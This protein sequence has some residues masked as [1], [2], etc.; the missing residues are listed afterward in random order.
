MNRIPIYGRQDL[1]NFKTDPNGVPLYF[2]Y[3]GIKKEYLNE[4]YVNPPGDPYLTLGVTTDIGKNIFLIV[5]KIRKKVVN[6]FYP[7]FYIGYCK[8]PIDDVLEIDEIN[9]RN[10]KEGRCK[11]LILQPYEGWNFLSSFN[12]FINTIIKKYNL[13]HDNFVIVS[14]NLDKNNITNV[15][16]N[17]W[18]Q[19]MRFNDTDLLRKIGYQSIYKEHRNYRFICLNRR[20]HIHRILLSSMLYKYK[21]KGILTLSKEVDYGSSRVYFNSLNE[22]EE[23]YPRLSNLLENEIQNL[24]N[25]L[26]LVYEDGINAADDNP[27][28]DENPAK[29]YDSWFHIVTETFQE[30]K[31]TFFSEKIFKPIIYYQPFI[32]INS[33]QSLKQF[34]TLG[35][36]T[37]NGIIDESYD[38]VVDDEERLMVAFREIERLINL[39]N[40]EIKELYQNCYDILV[41]NFNHWVYRQNTIHLQLKSN[42]FNI[43]SPSTIDLE[44]LKQK[45]LK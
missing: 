42:L 10:I 36:K 6:Y 41:H 23:R 40:V 20:P 4:V 17:Y 34:R 15:Y 38:N 1:E 2:F 7:M 45:M 39:S 44:I 16:Y 22:L 43:I 26:P 9:L 5:S 37:F 3:C 21:H 32:M 29:F 11:I 27:V 8:F 13:N 28:I 12:T 24:C 25:S 31:Q 14:G 19:H 18:E 33:Y 35:Y 30:S